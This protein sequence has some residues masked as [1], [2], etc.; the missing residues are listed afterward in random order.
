MRTIGAAAAVVV[1]MLMGVSVA[2]A[3]PLET[4]RQQEQQFDSAILAC[5]PSGATELYEDD[6]VA[7][8]PGADDIGRGKD[9]IA[10][11]LK[12]FSA[13][14][15]PNDSRKAALKDVSLAASPLG[16]NYIVVI[17]VMEATDKHGAQA[18]VRATKVIHHV[19][20]KWQYLVDHTSVGLNAAPSGAS[21]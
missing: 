17:R 10:K 3:G 18:L 14:F 9:A 11:L 12:D 4:A 5:N 1:I 2:S 8:Y 19:G 6:A 16:A 21:Q 20:G 7:I 15:C 13:A